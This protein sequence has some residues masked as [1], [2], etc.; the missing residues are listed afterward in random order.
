MIIQP[1]T[2]CTCQWS[3]AKTNFR[4]LG[5]HTCL[6]FYSC[7]CTAVPTLWVSSVS[8]GYPALLNELLS[9][10]AQKQNRN[11]ANNIVGSY[12]QLEDKFRLSWTQSMTCRVASQGHT[13][14]SAPTFEPAHKGRTGQRPDL[15]VQSAAAAI[16]HLDI[17][18]PQAS[19]T[20]RSN[21]NRKFSSVARYRRV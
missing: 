19:P 7:C 1:Y 6:I 9:K 3:S 12:A 15:S 10:T 8:C 5:M 18:N 4:Y 14:C 16:Q 13:N 17:S 21:D 2:R 11:E 20:R